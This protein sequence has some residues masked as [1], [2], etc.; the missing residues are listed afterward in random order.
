MGKGAA[1]LA[2]NPMLARIYATKPMATFGGPRALPGL[3]PTL[4]PQ[5]NGM[6]LPFGWQAT[7]NAATGVTP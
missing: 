6:T 4:L 7:G 5:T 3:F 1:A 2:V